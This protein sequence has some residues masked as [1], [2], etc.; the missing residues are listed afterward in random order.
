MPF[1]NQKMLMP[2]FQVFYKLE[3]F[4]K[5]I[6]MRQGTDT[7]VRIENVELVTKKCS[8]FIEHSG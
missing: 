4:L 3:K 1:L 6:L 5:A 7:E 8:I 2:F